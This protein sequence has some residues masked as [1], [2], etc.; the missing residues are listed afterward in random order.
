MPDYETSETPPDTPPGIDPTVG[1]KP[2]A[3]MADEG[4]REGPVLKDGTHAGEEAP[5]SSPPI[6]RN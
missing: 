5:N 2:S 1:P 3:E 6:P 4:D